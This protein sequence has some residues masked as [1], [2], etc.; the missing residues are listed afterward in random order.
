VTYQS[1]LTEPWTWEIL[2]VFKIEDGLIAE[3]EALLIRSPYGM[4][5][6]WSGSDDAMSEAI[7]DVTGVAAR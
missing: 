2:E 3:I 7:Q 1:R 4:P 5:S 6:G